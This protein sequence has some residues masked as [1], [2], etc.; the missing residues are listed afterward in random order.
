MGAAVPERRAAGLHERGP[1]PDASAA[2]PAATGTSL[3]HV[4]LIDTACETD[5]LQG[6]RG[7]LSGFVCVLCSVSKCRVSY[8]EI[9]CS[10]SL[11]AAAHAVA[12]IAPVTPDATVLLSP[13]A[14][15]VT[16]PSSIELQPVTGQLSSRLPNAEL[17][18]AE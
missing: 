12:A 18:L 1:G 5:G 13:A 14:S 7:S 2:A 6:H 3:R 9:L 15:S 4:R 11:S 16:L 10:S 8:A 17:S